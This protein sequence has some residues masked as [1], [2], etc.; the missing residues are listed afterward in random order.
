[1]KNHIYIYIYII[2]KLDNKIHNKNKRTIFFFKSHCENTAS[3]TKN[4]M[5]IEKEK[6]WYIIFSTL[7]F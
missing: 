2:F 4:F 1:M 3:N 6:L 7:I 5:I